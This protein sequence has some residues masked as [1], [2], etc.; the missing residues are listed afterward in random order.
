MIRI[1]QPLIGEEERAAVM[2]VLDSGQLAAGPVTKRLE[3][4]FARD[5][6]QTAEAVAVSNGTAALHIALLAH[7]IGPGDEV[8]TSPFTFQATGNMILAAGATPVFVDV[9]EDGNIDVSQI[10]VAITSRT[11]AIMPV[12]LYGRLADMTAIEAI[13]RKHGLV[14]IEDAAQAHLATRDGRR[15]AGS[16]GTGCFSFYATKNMAAGEGGMITT[17]DAALAARMRRIRHHGQS[18]TYS[19]VE[20]G[21]NY[22]TT[23]L[24]SA[25][26]LAQ[27]HRLPDLTAQRRANAA[28]L[29]Q[30]LRGITPPPA[31]SDE[32][33]VW[34][35]YTVRVEE[36][37]DELAAY[38]REREIGTG[39]FYPYILPD[40]PL[41]RD[42]GFRGDW[43]M[44][45]RLTREVLSLPVHPGLTRSDL[46]QV[47][48]AVNAWSAQKPI[49]AIAR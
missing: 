14:V 48:E 36:G 3:E 16:F 34:H 2:A 31:P 10:E 47:V 33:M 29:T 22:R 42:R 32:S 23:D 40:H 9:M 24:A 45:R 39:L 35:Q 28:F 13:A 12:H 27:L 19:S 37:R 41:Y 7:D 17:N 30:H 4:E 44:A 11:R 15:R 46:E 18:E 43:P 21:Y 49:Q 26:A 20:L 6:S 8:I 1:A 38:L 25:I 5:V